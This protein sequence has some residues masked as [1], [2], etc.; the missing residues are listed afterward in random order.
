MLISRLISHNPYM[1][2]FALAA[3]AKLLHSTIFFPLFLDS[4]QQNLPPLQYCMH[5][6]SIFYQLS[7]YLSHFSFKFPP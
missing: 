2:Q 5:L 6:P 1:I 3:N 7:T 4:R